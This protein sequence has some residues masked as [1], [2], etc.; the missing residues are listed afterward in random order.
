ML[1]FCE[2]HVTCDPQAQ[3]QTELY[4]RDE[5]VLHQRLPLFPYDNFHRSILFWVENEDDIGTA[6]HILND[7]VMWCPQKIHVGMFNPSS[8]FYFYSRERRD[9][10]IFSH[11][12]LRNN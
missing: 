6:Y 10:A 12:R 11:E 7:T 8:R 9:E 5:P 1:L 2:M 4:P 3:V